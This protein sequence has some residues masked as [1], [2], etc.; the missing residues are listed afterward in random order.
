MLP[1]IYLNRQTIGLKTYYYASFPFN[2]NIYTH[3]SSLK[4]S[5]WDSFEK[6]WIIDEAAFPLENIFAY[7]KDKATSRIIIT[8]NP[9]IKPR[10]A[11]SVYLSRCVSGITSS[12]TTKIIAPAANASAKGKSGSM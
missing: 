8:T 9:P 5:T 12:T 7:F 4:N 10:T 1:V 3:F 2:R 11:T 6:A